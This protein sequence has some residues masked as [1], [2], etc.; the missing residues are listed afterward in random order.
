MSAFGSFLPLLQHLEQWLAGDWHRAPINPIGGLKKVIIQ[1]RR[2]KLN[3]SERKVPCGRPLVFFNR[4]FKLLANK[5]NKATSYFK[6]QREG[7]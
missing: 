3:E 5:A 1:T 6:K 4:G 7:S 2:V